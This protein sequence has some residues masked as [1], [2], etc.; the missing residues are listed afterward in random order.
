MTSY[1]FKMRLSIG[2]TVGGDCWNNVLL[3]SIKKGIWSDREKPIVSS[4]VPNWVIYGSSEY[5]LK[6]WNTLRSF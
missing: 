1:I 5:E 6:Q 4:T 3:M 2:S